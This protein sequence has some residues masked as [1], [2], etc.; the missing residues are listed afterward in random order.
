MKRDRPGLNGAA[1][2]QRT[3]TICHQC[4]ANLAVRE[5]RE[6]D[7]LEQESMASV[8]PRRP[9]PDDFFPWLIALRLRVDG[10]ELC[11]ISEQ[12]HGSPEVCG[13]CKYGSATTAHSVTRH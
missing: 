13:S 3:Q 8:A 9:W 6:T 12:S 4:F 5:A 7:R 1:T 11:T 2:G 10:V